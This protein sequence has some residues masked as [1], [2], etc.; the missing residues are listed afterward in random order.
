ML[1][2]WFHGSFAT[3]LGFVKTGAVFCFILDGLDGN[4]NRLLSFN[5]D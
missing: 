4:G 5:V 1:F 3:G 2:V